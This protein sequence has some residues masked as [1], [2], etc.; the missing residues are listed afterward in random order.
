MTTAYHPQCNGLTER[1]NATLISMISMHVDKSQRE[2]DRALHF[3]T[4][5]YNGP[6]NPST[7]FFPFY[8]MHGREP[9]T[10]IDRPLALPGDDVRMEGYAAN[11]RRHLEFIREVA[12]KN[13]K[14]SQDKS[15]DRA[16]ASRRNVEF[17]VGDLVLVYNPARKVG[18]SISLFINR[19]GRLK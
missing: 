5:A 6:V 3:L 7:K 4:F 17:S 10:P 15:K 2:W 14:S 9:I 16:D 18:R 11:L 12:L 19:L 13:L 1:F 8:L